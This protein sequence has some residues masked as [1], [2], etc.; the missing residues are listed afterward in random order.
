MYG[1]VWFGAA[2]SDWASHNEPRLAQSN[3]LPMKMADK[4]LLLDNIVAHNENANVSRFG[5]IVSRSI[6]VIASW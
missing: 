4:P 6:N 2:L 3:A 5:V 1:L